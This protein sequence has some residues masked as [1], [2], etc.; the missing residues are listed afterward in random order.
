MLCE[1]YH[2]QCKCQPSVQLPKPTLQIQNVYLK[3]VIEDKIIH[4]KREHST[5]EMYE[6]KSD[7]ESFLWGQKI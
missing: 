1:R 5:N 6:N 7:S 4:K 2:S 3:C